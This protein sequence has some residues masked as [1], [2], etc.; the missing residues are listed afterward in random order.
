MTLK[1]PRITYNSDYALGLITRNFQ[2]LEFYL[3]IFAWG[4]MGKNQKIGQAVTAHLSFS[5]LLTLVDALF[6]ERTDEP[7]LIRGLN[8]I[9]AQA[10]DAEQKRNRVIHSSYLQT[11]DD[12][13]AVQIRFKVTSKLKKGLVYQWEDTSL[14]DLM[15]IAIELR[16]TTQLLVT[17]IAAVREPLRIDFS[18]VNSPEKKQPPPQQRSTSDEDDIPF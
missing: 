9:L 13:T 15:D 10:A 11:S 8:P 16:Q 12:L 1:D 14:D 4:L 17:F 7:N 5:K 18:G 6:R 2:I 3:S